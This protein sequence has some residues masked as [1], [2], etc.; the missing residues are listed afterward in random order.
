[1]KTCGLKFLN[2]FGKCNNKCESCTWF[3]EE[4]KLSR[5]K[6]RKQEHKF[7]LKLRRNGKK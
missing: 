7:S 2:A 6:E 4:D 1:M 3:T 5:T